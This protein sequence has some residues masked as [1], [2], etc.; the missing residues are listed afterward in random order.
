MCLSPSYS[1]QDGFMTLQGA[2]GEEGALPPGARARTTA[3]QNTRR[4]AGGDLK[5]WKWDRAG[6]WWIRTMTDLKLFLCL[7]RAQLA[8]LR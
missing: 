1:C 2:G 3:Q 7:H 8:D 5:A 4:G 6:I